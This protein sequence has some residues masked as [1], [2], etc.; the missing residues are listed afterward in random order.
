MR[1]IYLPKGAS[2]ILNLPSILVVA[3][4]SMVLSRR[5]RVTVANS[6]GLF[7][8]AAV[9]VPLRVWLCAKTLLGA[10][11]NVCAKQK[12]RRKKAFFIIKMLVYILINK[13]MY[14]FL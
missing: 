14:I 3:P 1:S 9:T 12:N 10:K 2:F 13:I 5:K 8:S 6:I 11:M 4:S 7:V